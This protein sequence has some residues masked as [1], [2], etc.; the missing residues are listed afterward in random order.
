MTIKEDKWEEKINLG[1]LNLLS[2]AELLRYFHLISMHI[3]FTLTIKPH[4]Y[5]SQCVVDSALQGSLWVASNHLFFFLKFPMCFLC[6]CH[7]KVGLSTF[8]CVTLSPGLRLFPQAAQHFARPSSYVEESSFL[9]SR[10]I[11]RPLYFYWNRND[12]GKDQALF[13][14][15]WEKILLWLRHK[16][17]GYIH[18]NVMLLRCL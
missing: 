1:Y 11:T 6:E 15:G 18:L 16:A 14:Q 9:K 7:Y 13:I 2:A 8:A 10:P 17:A 4:W 5:C 12:V 3:T